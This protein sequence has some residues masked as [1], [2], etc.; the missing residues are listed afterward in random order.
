MTGIAVTPEQLHT[1]A[2]T[3]TRTSADVRGAHQSLRGQLAPLFGADWRGAASTQ[4]AGLYDQFDQHAKGLSD[5]L[6]A[7]GQLL[8]RAGA[9]Y[10]EA[11]QQIAASFH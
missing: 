3:V 10:A 7:I 4:F 2:G 5:A 1:L 9:S 11:E 8:G 6:D